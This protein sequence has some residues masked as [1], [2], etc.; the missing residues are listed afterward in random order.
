MRGLSCKSNG[1]NLGMAWALFDP[2]E[3]M[4]QQRISFR[5]T[6]RHTFMSTNIRLRTSSTPQVRRRASRSLLSLSLIKVIANSAYANLAMERS[7]VAQI[8]GMKLQ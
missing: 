1:T 4:L 5:T 8:R 3:I 7:A 2:W 6:P